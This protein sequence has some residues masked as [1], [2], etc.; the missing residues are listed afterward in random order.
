MTY[1]LLLAMTL[2]VSASCGSDDSA[3]SK[4]GAVADQ[5]I[6][7][8][9]NAAPDQGQAPDALQVAADAPPATGDAA[10]G[11]WPPPTPYHSGKACALPPCDPNGPETTDLSGK[12]TQKITTVSQTCNPLARTMNKRLQPGNVETLTG[13]SFLR[14]GEC[15]YGDKIGGTVIGVIK[16]NVMIICQVMP[17]VSGVTPLVEGQITF[18]GNTASG[19]AWT[20]LFD[21]P[22]PPANCQANGTVDLTRE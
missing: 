22:L 17:V 7:P 20:Y 15:L 12:W 3:P 13:Q 14:A 1:R 8:D 10:Q 6:A 5:G 11:A 16:G 2:M 18:S 21:V 9:V 4:D 19:P